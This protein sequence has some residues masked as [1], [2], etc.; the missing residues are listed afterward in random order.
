MQDS[1][2][3]LEDLKWKYR[4]VLYFQDNAV[5]HL[6]MTDSITKQID[7]RKIAYY[8]IGDSVSSNHNLMFSPAYIQHLKTKYKMG[9]KGT[10]Y[11]L[12]GLDGGV[13]LKKEEPLDWTLIFNSIDSMPMRKSEMSKSSG[14]Y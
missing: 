12:L 1:Q 8:A 4:V 5:D 11:V 13:K 7:E 3:T 10:M 9:Y 14:S 2:S 6:V